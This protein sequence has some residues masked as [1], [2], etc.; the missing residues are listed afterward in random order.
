MKRLYT[1][2]SKNT[3]S[4]S[5]ATISCL[6]PY[7]PVYIIGETTTGKGTGMRT[8]S[9]TKCRI[10]ISPLTFRYYNADHETVPDSGLTPDLYC[11][12]GYNTRK[13]DIGDINEPLLSATLQYMGLDVENEVTD[14]QKR[15]RQ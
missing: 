11:P 14:I 10:D 15:A 7:M 13:K 2:T 12:D 1:I 4:A 3:A 8:F 9:N 6:R 5:E